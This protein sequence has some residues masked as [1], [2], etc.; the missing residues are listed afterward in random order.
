MKDSVRRPPIEIDVVWTDS[1]GVITGYVGPDTPSEMWETPTPGPHYD[2]F[3]MNNF[4]Y[5]NSTE[6]STMIDPA[7]ISEADKILELSH[8]QMKSPLC[9]R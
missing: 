5:D 4:H 1:G 2:M 6:L 9:W 8:F 7:K 3:D